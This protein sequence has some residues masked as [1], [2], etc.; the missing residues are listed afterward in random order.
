MAFFRDPVANIINNKWMKAL[1]IL[2]F[3]GYLCGAA[4]GVTQIKEGLERRKLSKSDSYSIKFYDLEDEYYREFPYRI[5]VAITGNLNY[6]DPETQYQIEHV[7][8]Q[9]ENTTYVTSSRYTESW[10]RTF[11]SYVDSTRIDY[12]NKTIDTELDFITELREVKH[13]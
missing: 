2:V 9:L 4:Y 11:L 12:P 1:I 10:L 3:V 8:R 5:Q 6:S 7:L 13:F